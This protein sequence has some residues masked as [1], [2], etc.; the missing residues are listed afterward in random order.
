MRLPARELRG[1]TLVETLAATILSVAVIGLCIAGMLVAQRLAMDTDLACQGRSQEVAGLAIG[2]REQARTSVASYA[3]GG[4]LRL[5][6]ATFD[7]A[8]WSGA[9]GWRSSADAFTGYSASLAAGGNALALLTAGAGEARSSALFLAADGRVNSYWEIYNV[10]ETVGGV[11][12]LTT[13][14]QWWADNGTANLS[15]RGFYRQFIEAGTLAAP[16]GPTGGPAGGRKLPGFATAAG[17]SVAGTL[18]NPWPAGRSLSFDDLELV[19]SSRAQSLVVSVR[20][21]SQP[22]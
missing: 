6:G 11:V 4:H 7:W 15:L 1:F 16:G 22:R 14:V 19:E 3:F 21:W 12:G 18:P 10:Q 8:T 2:L 20:P 13:V 9:G 5:N 17:N